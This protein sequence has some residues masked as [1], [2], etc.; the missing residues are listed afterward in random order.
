MNRRG[1]FSFLAVA[2]VAA[3][4]PATE[5]DNEVICRSLQ[6][7]E[8]VTICNL[9]R[10]NLTVMAGDRVVTINNRT[11]LITLGAQK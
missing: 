6:V 1:F 8:L 9:G 7:G 3:V 5:A 11:G 10:G 4:V 2:P